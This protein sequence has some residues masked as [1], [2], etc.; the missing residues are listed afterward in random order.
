MEKYYNAGYYLMKLKPIEFGADKD[1]IVETC[2]DCINFSVF[3]YWCLSWTGDKLTKEQ[4]IE[5]DLTDEKISAIQK[6]TDDKFDKKEIR[7]GNALPDLEAVLTFKSL[8]FSNI[9]N[10]DIYTIYFSETDTDSLIEEFDKD[11]MNNG[12]FGLRINLMKKNENKSATNEEFL[13]YDFIGVEG[14]GSFHSFYC[15]NITTALVNQFSLVIN[16]H[17]LFQEIKEPKRLKDYLNI[18]E[19]GLEPVPWYIVKTMKIILSGS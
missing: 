10:I 13:G 3:D 4:K 5:L 14:D 8:F 11:G 15:H 19:N 18:P 12:N 17:G 6:W 1:K 16:E 9:K 7:W 2:S